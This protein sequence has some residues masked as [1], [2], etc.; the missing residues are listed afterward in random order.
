MKIAIC[1]DEKILRNKLSAYIKSYDDKSVI[2]EY[3]N[4][5][6]L[7]RS[8]VWYDIIFLDIEMPGINGMSVAEKLRSKNIEARIIFLT[9]HIECVHDAFK[10]KAFRFLNKPIDT[11]AFIEAMKEA[12]T[13][14]LNT[15]KIVINQKGRIY[16]ID[17]KDIVY[18]EAFGDGTYVYDK[19]NNVYECSTQLKEWDKNLQG[20][21]FF[22]IHKSFIVSLL[23]VKKVENNQ[24]ELSNTSEPFTISRRNLARFKEEYLQ[25]I[26]N[27]AR[28][29]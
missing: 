12:E 21:G 24:L 18:F 8:S 5:H 23:Y 4:G 20:K 22:K 3:E 16:E 10:V 28:V 13:E 9:S 2:D 6:E 7:L 1:D 29:I 15:E 25:F 27:N 14:I 11:S 19:H 26:K 17:L